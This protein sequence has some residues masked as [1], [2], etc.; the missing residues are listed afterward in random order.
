[1]LKTRHSFNMGMLKEDLSI[2][3]VV[4]G[5]IATM[6]SYA[7]PLVIVFQ[8]AKVAHLSDS[9]LSSWIWAISMGSGITCILLSIWFKAPIITA[10]STPGVVLLVSSWSTYSYTDAIGAFI[11]S[12]LIIT[13]L[14]FTGIFEKMMN[15]IPYSITTAMLAGILLNFG[16]EVFTSL[17][18]LP[19][20]VF[21]MILCYLLFKRFSPRYTVVITLFLGLLITYF[22]GNL[23]TDSID[24]SL[25][26]P[27]FTIPTFSLD[28]LIGIGVPLCIVT[29]ASQNAPGIGVLRADGYNVPISPLVTTTGIFSIL[30]APFGSH[31][32]NLAAI[33]AAICT[34]KEAHEDKN[35]RYIAGISCGLFYL[36]FGLFGAAIASIFQALPG[37]FIATIAG[38]ALFASLSSSL[39]SA[40][41]GTQKESAL[42][43]F[44]VTISGISFLGIGAAFWGLIAGILTNSIFQM[45]FNIFS[46]NKR[47]D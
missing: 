23:K 8:A 47:I 31:A 38:L 10:W 46:K 16:V 4:V 9:H 2:S 6:V 11:F 35:K 15:R 17:R 1:M 3:S 37:E 5:L 19:E 44:L 41:E 7:G 39:A 34:G 24:I 43:T 25:V 12:A 14:G 40:M 22:T 28:A 29:M 36:I 27:I 45:N 30:L 21:P 32:I 26:N 42:I 18:N 13:F 20:L 33:T